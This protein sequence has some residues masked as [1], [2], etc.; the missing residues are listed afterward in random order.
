MQHASTFQL[1][2]DVHCAKNVYDSVKCAACRTLLTT[3]E[4]LLHPSR[5]PRMNK[6]Q[7]EQMLKDYTGVTKVRGSILE[8][9]TWQQD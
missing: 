6:A 7:I 8:K 4:C 2:V 5:N 9:I 3:E 1:E